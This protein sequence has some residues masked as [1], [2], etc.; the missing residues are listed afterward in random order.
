MPCDMSEIFP[1]VVTQDN[2]RML[3]KV[4]DLTRPTPARQDAPF[5]RQGRSK[6]RDAKNN[7][8]H[9]AMNKE[10]YVCARRRVGE[11]A[12]S[13]ERRWRTFSASC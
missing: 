1:T 11:S 5:H 7:E 8:A 13:R 4:A 6:V 12:V 9:G 2:F 10:H 3:K